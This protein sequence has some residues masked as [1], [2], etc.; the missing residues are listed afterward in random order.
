MEAPKISPN[1]STFAAPFPSSL[2]AE[3]RARA[4]ASTS[5]IPSSLFAEQQAR[6]EASTS[7]IAWRRRSSEHLFL[8]HCLERAEQRAAWRGWSSEHLF[9]FHYLAPMEQRAPL[10]LLGAGGAASTSSSSITWRRRSS[11]HLF[12]CL[13]RAEQRAPLPL[14]SPGNLTRGVCFPLQQEVS[15][16]TSGRLS[17]S[18]G[19]LTGGGSLTDNLPVSPS[20][21]DDANKDKFELRLGDEVCNDIHIRKIIYEI[22]GRRYRDVRSTL[23][24][25]YQSYA[26]DE[27]RLQNPLEDINANEWAWLVNYFGSKKFKAMSEKNKINRSKHVISHIT[28]RRSF[29]QVSWAEETVKDKLEELASQPCDSPVASTPEEVLSLVVGQRSGYV[30][31]RG[32]GPKPPSKSVVTTAT[33]AGLQ[34]QVKD[35]DERISQM[36]ELISKQREEVAQI[37]EK[38]F[39]QKEEVTA[40]V[41]ARLQIK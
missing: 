13:A 1:P 38:L 31:G 16:W 2:F 27:D 35:K 8:F 34:A 6:A 41:T 4:E 29:K 17:H 24:R 28:G 5:S 36:E 18:S 21:A 33:I 23:Y 12:H 9:L 7:S 25:H 3:Q 19:P 30:R 26:T 11:E 22:A 40:E 39:K 10:P 14:P 15:P 20:D 32:C 37:Q